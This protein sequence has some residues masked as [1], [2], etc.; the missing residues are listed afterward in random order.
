[1]SR[2]WL[3]LWLP[4]WP[5]DRAIRTGRYDPERPLVTA[6]TVADRQ[7]VVAVSRAAAMAGIVPGRCVAE[8]RAMEPGVHVVAADP[9]GDSAA[10]VR[11]AEW[12]ERWSP[13]VVPDGPD[14]LALELSG[15]VPL[16]SSEAALAEDMLGRLRRWGFSVRAAVADTVAAARAVAHFGAGQG[17]SVVQPGGQREA[18]APLP[19]SSLRLDSTTAD[20]LVRVGLRRIGDLYPLPRPSLA[21]RYG[22]MVLRR[23]DEALGLHD[24]PFQ[25]IR[26][27][28]LCL[29]RQNLAE[30]IATQDVLERIAGSLLARLCR[31]LDERQFGIREMTLSAWRTDGRVARATVVT[32]RPLRR[33]KALAELL[34]LKL[35]AVDLGPGADVVALAAGKVEPLL[36]TQASLDGGEAV[37]GDIGMLVDKVVNRCGAGAL[38]SLAPNDSHWPE[39]E[40]CTVDP[41]SSAASSPWPT[42]RPRPIR[43]F[44]PPEPVDAM[45]QMPDDPPVM[46]RWR[47]RVHRVRLAEGPER[48]EPEWWLV[49]R[50]MPP[51]DY[52]RVE[53]SVGGRYWLFRAG[54]YE[55]GRPQPR[56]FL[57][58]VF[59]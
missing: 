36:P 13:C 24:E 59:G 46:F 8:A 16:F 19:V 40:S 4:D 58:G 41:L 49:G 7:V 33:V 55:P 34:A 27:I 10:L 26:P 31:D 5:T 50:D 44:R 29:V 28:P 11:L 9:A 39:R 15:C 22:D 35:P 48:M 43:L 57:H 45:A 23:L 1:M 21:K 14:G 42:D 25:A 3:S 17:V 12:A 2:R 37:D 56:W 38:A 47:G 18:M 20:G 30:P 6:T 52:Y 32:G 51:R 54:R 53:D